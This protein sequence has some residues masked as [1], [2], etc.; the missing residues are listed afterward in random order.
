MELVK[1]R[2]Q[3][4]GD[5]GS[6]INVVRNIYELEGVRGV[7]RGLSITMA[8]EVPAFSGY[9][10]TYE[11]LTRTADDSVVSTMRM[12]MAGGMAGVVSW[13]LCYPIDIIKSRMQVDGMNGVRTYKNSL[14]CLRKSVSTEGYAFLVRGLTPAVIRAFPVNAVCFTVVTWTMRLLDK[15][16]ISKETPDISMWDTLVYNMHNTADSSIIFI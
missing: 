5:T 3:L 7:F 2:M 4:S 12:L 11:C 1:T 16:T 10:L 13:I 8:R 9:F 6:A 14:D 15:V